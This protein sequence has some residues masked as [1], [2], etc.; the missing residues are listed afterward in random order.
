MCMNDLCL[1]VSVYVCV[2]AHAC[3]CT[4]TRTC[5][6]R[7]AVVRVWSSE[8]SLA[9]L[10]FSFNL[11]VGSA[12]WTQVTGHAWQALLPPCLP[13]IALRP[14]CTQMSQQSSLPNLL[15]CPS[16]LPSWI[17]NQILA[18]CYSSK[19]ETRWASSPCN[20]C[21]PSFLNEFAFSGPGLVHL[22]DVFTS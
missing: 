5:V 2:C 3:L 17:F 19:S 16:Y 21:S 20:I 10:S 9:E 18:L 4:C 1:S 11:Y 7:H 6:G 12:D 14:K 22:R 8:D 15:F 13:L